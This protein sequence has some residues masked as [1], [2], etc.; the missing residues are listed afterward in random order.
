MPNS[1]IESSGITPQL[2]DVLGAWTTD[3]NPIGAGGGNLLGST[4]NFGWYFITNNVRRGGWSQTGERLLFVDGVNPNEYFRELPLT[5]K[6]YDDFEDYMFRTY[7]ADNTLNRYIID[8]MF[9]SLDG[10]THGTFRREIMGLTIGGV[11]SLL[12]ET[13]PHTLINDKRIKVGFKLFGR[14]LRFNI[15]GLNKQINW[16]GKITYQGVSLTP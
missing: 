4:D 8:V 5:K 3:G 6:T 10:T 11:S 15:K 9:S 16:S 1:R 12:K 7:L 2:L 14:E 13:T